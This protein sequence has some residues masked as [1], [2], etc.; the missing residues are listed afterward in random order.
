[1]ATKLELNVKA[2]SGRVNVYDVSISGIPVKYQDVHV[3]KLHFVPTQGRAFSTMSTK[4]FAQDSPVFLERICIDCNVNIYFSLNEFPEV[5]ASL[6]I[7]ASKN[8]E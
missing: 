1:M 6:L 5:A 7:E 2:V 3:Y 8:S 4:N